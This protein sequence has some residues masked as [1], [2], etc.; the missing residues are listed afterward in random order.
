MSSPGNLWRK[1]HGRITKKPTNFSWILDGRLAGSGRP[2]SREEFDW[3]TSQGVRCIVTMTEDALPSDWIDSS[4]TV[5]LHVPTPD[6]T[7][8]AQERL[9]AAADFIDGHLKAGRPVAVHC[10][11][12][13]GRAGTVLACYLVKYA[14]YDAQ[15]AINEIR[16]KRPG[17]IQSKEQE[18]AVDFFARQAAGSRGSD[19]DDTSAA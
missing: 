8:P 17:S 4:D 2:T 15:R 3:I 7:A 9:D 11:A 6:L 1:V 14:R 18:T 16:Q 13:L 12:G 5:Y 19:D 10:A